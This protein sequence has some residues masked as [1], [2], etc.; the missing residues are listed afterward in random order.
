MKIGIDIM[1]G[2]YAPQSSL[3]GCLNA[4]SKIDKDASIVLFGNQE[5]IF[6]SEFHQEIKKYCELGK[7]QIVDCPQVIEMHEHPSESIKSKPNSSIVMGLKAHKM[8]QIDA[9][10]SAGNTGA[11]LVGAVLINGKIPG[12]QR[13][14]IGALY[15]VDNGFSLICD[16][17]ANMDCKPEH[18]RDFAILGSIYM[19]TVFRIE[20]PKVALLNVGEEKG[21]GNQ[22][23]KE[24]YEQLEKVSNINFIGNAEGRDLNKHLADV[25]VCDGF[26]G[27]ILLKFGESFY[28][29]LKKI[30]NDF[31]LLQ[32]F[33]FEAYGGT[34]F[35]GINGNVVIGHG[36]SSEYA[37]ENMILK[38]QDLIKTQLV[39]KIQS[40]FA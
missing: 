39:R 6:N 28:D 7:F 23:V 27:N 32:K 15:P 11:M 37:F 3:K 9:F 24:A 29:L 8:N 13:P 31:G 40:Y 20:N 12:L 33:N 10:I 38:A 18:L 14:T 34:P 35:L 17:G 5:V 22:Q 1:G 19:K 36:I 26:V 4:V 25:Y 30:K 2:D 16:V 21:K